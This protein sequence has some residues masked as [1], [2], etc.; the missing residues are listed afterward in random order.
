MPKSSSISRSPYSRSCVSTVT[1]AC[2]SSIS[3]LSVISSAS[4]PGASPLRRAI[5]ATSAGNA[6]SAIWC[7]RGVDAHQQRLAGPRE[8]LLQRARR[9]GTRASSTQSPQRADQPRLLGHR[10]EL[11]RAR[12]ARAPGAASARA[13]RPRR[14]C[15]L[16]ELDHRLVDDAQLVALER[17]PQ[18]GLGAQPREHALAQHVVEQLEAAAAALL[19]AVHRRVGV[20]HQRR[21]CRGR[22]SL[23]HRD[24][25]RRGD[26][27]LAG[28][29]HDRLRVTAWATRSAT[30]DRVVR[31]VELLAHD[32]EL[33]AAEPR[34]GV[35]RPDR[36]VQPRRQRRRA[37]RRR[38]R[39]RSESLTSL[40][41]SR[42]SRSTATSRP[43]RRRRA[44]AP[45]S[46][47]S[48]SARFGSPV[49]GSCSAAWRT[50]SST[51][52]AVDRARDD[53]GDRGQEVGLV[54]REAARAPAR[55]R[56]ARPTVRRAPAIAR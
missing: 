24:P 48:A 28:A 41:R 22:R 31:A 46:R 10:D 13:P 19:G 35:R 39:G 11:D 7:G 42:S 38:S 20:A 3:T 23:G 18:L 5:A 1:G 49:S 52:V 34:D 33:V 26:E 4:E 2:A 15:P 44:S 55:A 25:D 36:V 47:S 12:A 21:R 6:A 50:S 17:A 53:V 54:G 45:S 32:Q 30:L 56:R 29:Q 16:V 8:A 40:N 37:G 27:V 43:S 9:R 51:Q 14:I